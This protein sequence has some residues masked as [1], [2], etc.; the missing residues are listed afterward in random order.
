[1]EYYR[2]KCPKCGTQLQLLNCECYDSQWEPD[3]YV[4]LNVGTCPNCQTDLQWRAVYNFAG[5][6]NLEVDE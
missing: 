4:E 2:P 6:E 3:R 5:L 1:M